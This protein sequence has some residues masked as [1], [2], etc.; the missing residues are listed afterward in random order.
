[1]SATIRDVIDTED[2]QAILI[3]AFDAYINKCNG[4]ANRPLQGYGKASEKEKKEE[5]KIKA[6]NALDLLS[7][8]CEELN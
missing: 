8:I 5:W 7:E 6:E 1:M 4:I 3:Q 2:K